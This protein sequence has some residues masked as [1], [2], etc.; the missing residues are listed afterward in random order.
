MLDF[1]DKYNCG[2]HCELTDSLHDDLSRLG[3]EL[4]VRIELEDMLLQALGGLD[5]DSLRRA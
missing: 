4:A 5:D 2:D 1:N 3:E